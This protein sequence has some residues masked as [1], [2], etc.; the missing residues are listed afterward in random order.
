[1]CITSSL[2]LSQNHPDVKA[3][4]SLEAA[5]LE[6]GYL[7]IAT[8]LCNASDLKIGSLVAVLADYWRYIAIAMTG[9]PLS[10]CL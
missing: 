9:G 2:F 6:C 5:S 3:V 10:V 1:M 8:R 7:D 4:Y